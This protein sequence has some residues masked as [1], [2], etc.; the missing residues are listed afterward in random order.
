MKVLKATLE[1]KK[2]LEGTYEN[3]VVLGF[4]EDAKNNWVVNVNVLE[5]EN[6][7]VIHEKLQALPQIEYNPKIVKI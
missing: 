7:K 4:I 2:T 1:Q 5:D 3:G 6:F